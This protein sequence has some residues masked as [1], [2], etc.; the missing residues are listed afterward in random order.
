METWK[1][2]KS[3]DGIDGSRNPLGLLLFPNSGALSDS[4]RGSRSATAGEIPLPLKTAANTMVWHAAGLWNSA[5]ALRDADT[6]SKAIKVAK[7]LAKS[8]PL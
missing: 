7:E 5:G 1:A 4:V 8:A 6:K 2:F 3:K